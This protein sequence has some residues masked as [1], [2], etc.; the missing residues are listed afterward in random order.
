VIEHG[1]QSAGMFRL[2][3]GYSLLRDWEI[4]L[5]GAHETASVQI[6]TSPGELI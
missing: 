4:E 3:A 1:V 6:A 5:E 2:P